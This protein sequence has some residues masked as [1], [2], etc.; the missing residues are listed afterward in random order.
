M[1]AYPIKA[2]ASTQ[3]TRL[4]GTNTGTSTTQAYQLVVPND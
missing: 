3:I 2:V 4:I 1:L